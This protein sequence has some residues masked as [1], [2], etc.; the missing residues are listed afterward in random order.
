MSNEG[1]FKGSSRERV[2]NGDLEVDLEGN[3]E[4][5]FEEDLEGDLEVDL[6]GDSKGDF[7]GDI[8]HGRGLAVKL[9]SG[10]VQVRSGTGLVQFTAQI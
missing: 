5:D 7:R 10:E 4:V 2:F 8:G 6:E 9:R 3:L 1:Y